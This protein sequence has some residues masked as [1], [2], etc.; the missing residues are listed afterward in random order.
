MSAQQKTIF[1]DLLPSLAEQ[2]EENLWVN[3]QD[4]H[5]NSFASSLIAQEIN[6]VLRKYI[7]DEK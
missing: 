1:Y 6:D 3:S 5:P 4:Q 7:S 2:K